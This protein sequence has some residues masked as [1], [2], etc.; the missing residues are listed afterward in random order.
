MRY[1]LEKKNLAFWQIFKAIRLLFDKKKVD[2]VLYAG[3]QLHKQPEKKWDFVNKYWKWLFLRCFH[4]KKN[5]KNRA[6]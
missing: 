5:L 6:F 2:P 4:E 1:F 3:T